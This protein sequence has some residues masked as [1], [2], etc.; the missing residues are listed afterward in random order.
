[1]EKKIEKID[2]NVINNIKELSTKKEELFS[3]IGQAHLELRELKKILS[4]M[5]LEF[6]SVATRLNGILNDLNTKYPNGEINL[7]DGTVEY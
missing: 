4:A 2:D 1:M 6:D 5:E 3:N 7:N